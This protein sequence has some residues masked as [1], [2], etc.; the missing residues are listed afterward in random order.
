VILIAVIWFSGCS[1]APK[2]K[3]PEVQVPQNFRFDTLQVDTLTTLRWWELFDDPQ[4]KELIQIGLQNNQDVRIAA[5]RVEQAR[6]LHGFNKAD[7]FPALNLA[8]SGSRGDFAF[9][10]LPRVSN[11]FYATAVLSWELDFWGK[12]RNMTRAAKMEYLG[13]AYGM[14]SVQISLIAEIART[15]YLLLDYRER[16]N[17]A[18]KTLKLREEALHIIEQRFEKGII[19]EIDLNQAQIQKAVAET[20]IPYYERL[21]SKTENALSVLLGRSPSEITSQK[22]LDELNLPPDIPPGLPSTLLLRR[23]DV[24]QQEHML[25]AQLARVGVAQAMRI[26]SISLTGLLG[27]ASGELN[28]LLDS[29]SGTWNVGGSLVGP[30]FQFGKNLRRVDVEKAR[31]EE[32]LRQYEKTILQAFR[33]VDD[34]LVDIHT[35][36]RELKAREE[37][38][39]AA[40]NAER[41][42]MERYDKG[43]TSYLEVI[44]TQRS[45]FDAELALSQTRQQLFSAYV[46]L[47]KALGGGWIS[48]AEEVNVRTQGQS[49]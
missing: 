45:A 38:F 19:P 26:P 20:A 34:A 7:L 1:F 32:V 47:Y 23:P 39:R 12:Y 16:L 30:I 10:K 22:T 15:Y 36:K 13:S 35:L 4:L 37:H 6:A 14:R 40:K 25:R 27:L 44:E 8:A 28:T 21:A 9:M 43:V 17:I 48:Q 24:V 49:Q 29:E 42:A 3:Q 46:N 2:F 31:A 5:A 18:R 11:N 41:L 33:E